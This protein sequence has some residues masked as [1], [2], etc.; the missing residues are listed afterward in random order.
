MQSQ[1]EHGCQAC[2]W[3]QQDI[4]FTLLILSQ[5]IVVWFG[6]VYV[7]HFPRSLTN[8]N[9][10]LR[11]GEEINKSR[12]RKLEFRYKIQWHMCAQLVSLTNCCDVI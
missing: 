11:H 9:L 5:V 8:P 3:H 10:L 6:L 1:A 2:H 4:T 7:F 12:K